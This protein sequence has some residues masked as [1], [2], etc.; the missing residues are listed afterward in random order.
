MIPKLH[1]KGT[2][3]RGVAQYVL[4]DKEADTSE[5]VAW[6]ETRNLATN[7]PEAAWRVQ[8][9]TALDQ[10]RLKTEAG[11]KTTGRKSKA[12][13]LHL[14]LSWHPDEAEGLTKEEMIA[15]AEGALTALKAEGHQALFVCHDDEEQ[16]HVHIIVNRISPIDGRMLTSS[17]EKLALSK[18][19]QTYEQA[20]GK[21]YCEERVLNNAARARGTYV[22]G[23]KDVPRHIFELQ[24]GNDNEPWVVKLRQEQQAKDL[25]V[26]R[27]QIAQKRRHSGEWTTHQQDHLG[28]KAA[29]E[30]E[31]RR[32]TTIAKQAVG[33]QFLPHYAALEV[34]LYEERLAFLERE[35]S[36]YGKGLNI[37]KSI[38]WS[39]LLRQE[40]RSVAIKEAFGLLGGRVGSR[41]EVL[42]RAQ[43]R[44]MMELEHQEIAAKRDAGAEQTRKHQTR[45]QKQRQAFLLKR[46]D[47]IFRHQMED[48]WIATL[49]NERKAQRE[50]AWEQ[51]RSQ[52]A[53]IAFER[54]ATPEDERRKAAETFMG[55]MRLAQSKK[56]AER[57]KESDADDR[58]RE[59]IESHEKRQKRRAKKQR[60]RDDSD[61]G[62]PGR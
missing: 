42:R 26:R 5:R 28:A 48:S 1:K 22:R 36:L 20:R 50:A 19:A 30:K 13:V 62:D 41:S 31:H 29:L 38:D 17:K 8:A 58:T 3:F 55:R 18:W 11:I 14:T 7:N 4:H 60:E 34:E 12:C 57:S 46:N 24:A 61:R 59:L 25:D 23:Q 6:T 2:S 54:T 21:V 16:P 15:A 47:L 40:R 27:K 10:S 53:K 56:E 32:E 44:K 33:Q 49:W 43:Q 52:R 9:A 51:V 45:L 37:L 39:G 35:E